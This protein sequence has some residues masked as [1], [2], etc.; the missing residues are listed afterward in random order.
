M[1]ER[2]C[3]GHFPAY[4]RYF[5]AWQSQIPRNQD[6]D[7]NLEGVA[8]AAMLFNCYIKSGF[9]PWCRLRAQN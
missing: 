6:G 3:E 9:R 7:A 1:I 2:D 8:K 5:H 4:P